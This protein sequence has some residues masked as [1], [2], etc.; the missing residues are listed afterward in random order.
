[1]PWASTVFH[2]L[3]RHSVHAREMLVES[4]R[5]S[6]IVRGVSVVVRGTPCTWP[7][8]AVEVRGHNRG[9]PPK[10][11]KNYIPELRAR[12]RSFDDLCSCTYP[13]PVRFGP[14]TSLSRMM[15]MHKCCSIY[16][17]TLVHASVLSSISSRLCL[18]SLHQW[19]AQWLAHE[20]SSVVGLRK[21]SGGC[22]S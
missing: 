4:S 7:W 18:M 14:S 21:G 15:L 16:F 19:L 20:R 8:G 3:S 22:S 13:L 6:T 12:T 17:L 10:R 11:Q 2:Y 1:M 9:I 5:R